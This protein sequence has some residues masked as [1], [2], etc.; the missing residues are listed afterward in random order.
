MKHLYVG[1]GVLIVAAGLAACGG[2]GGGSGSGSGG[3]LP[4][5]PPTPISATYSGTETIA[6]VYNSYPCGAPCGDPNVTP[7]PNNTVTYTLSDS[8]SSTPGSGNVTSNES[9]K[10]PNEELDSRLLVSVTPSPNGAVTNVTL[11]SSNYSDSDG[12]S[13]QITYPSGAGFIVDQNPENN[14]AH[15]TNVATRTTAELYSDG[16]KDNRS[17]NSD[18]SYTETEVDSGIGSNDTATV[19]SDGSGSWVA[20]PGSYGF[21]GGFFTSFTWTAPSGGSINFTATE[22]NSN[23]ETLSVAQWYATSPILASSS[24]TI[25]TGVTFPGACNVPAAYGTT[26]NDVHTSATDLD[27]LFGFYETTTTDAYTTSTDGAVCVRSVDVLDTY[28]DWN[29]DEY[30]YLFAS[31]TPLIA[32]TTTTTLTLESGGGVGIT[33]TGRS[34]QT[35]LQTSS[36]NAA[37]LANAGVVAQALVRGEATRLRAAAQRR[38]LSIMAA[39]ANGARL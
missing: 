29:D 27:T 35:A 22:Y 4:P 17:T 3:S 24:S 8:V 21:L 5:P 11:T 28:Y 39:R 13:Q 19:N 26:G 14:A 37:A 33:S 12:Y 2:S 16:T 6:N 9:V 36:G 38:V 15:W 32:T 18:G 23:T 25:T 10:E 1:F 7:Y 31:S 34:T 30:Y 20:A